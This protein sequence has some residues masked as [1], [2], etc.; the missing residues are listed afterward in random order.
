MHRQIIQ[1][2][3]ITVII[4]AETHRVVMGTGNLKIE[5]F[6]FLALTAVRFS[7]EKVLTSGEK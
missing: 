4:N 1:T 5:L 7:V 2:I 3:R 6:D